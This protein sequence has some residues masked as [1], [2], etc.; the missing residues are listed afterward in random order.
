MSNV[1][2]QELNKFRNLNGKTVVAVVDGSYSEAYTAIMNASDRI[3]SLTWLDFG[4]KDARVNYIDYSS[5]SYGSTIIRY[6]FTYTLTTG[7][8]RLDN[9]TISII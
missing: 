6:T 1:K 7:S 3:K 2:D 5:P 9:E 4:T 8:Y